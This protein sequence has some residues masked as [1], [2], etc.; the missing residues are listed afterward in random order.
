MNYKINK[1]SDHK[2]SETLNC[3]CTLKILSFIVVLQINQKIK[4]LA[5]KLPTH[6]CISIKFKS[7]I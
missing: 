1:R 4:S 3:T 5:R 2:Y 6:H 7:Q